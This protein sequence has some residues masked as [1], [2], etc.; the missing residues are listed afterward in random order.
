MTSERA[1]LWLGCCLHACTSYQKQ[2]LSFNRR[3]SLHDLARR[4]AAVVGDSDDEDGPC[5]SATAMARCN[6]HSQ[7][8]LKN[9][10]MPESAAE[11][12]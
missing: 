3:R 12:E 1:F 8:L 9:T 7:K 2:Q 10:C 4:R 6:K 11:R 5:S